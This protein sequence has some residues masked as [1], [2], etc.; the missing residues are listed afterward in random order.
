ML[1]VLF[2]FLLNNYLTVSWQ[3]PGAGPLFGDQPATMQSWLQRGVYIACVAAAA[4]FTI[5]FVQR[6]LRSDAQLITR[7][8]TFLVRGAF[9]AVLFV[10]VADMAISFL[11]VEGLLAS[12]VGASTSGADGSETLWSSEVLHCPGSQCFV[13]VV[14]KRRL[15]LTL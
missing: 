2:A 10:G 13:S 12:G 11:R 4:L 6:T 5:G 15:P 1:A 8:N 9:W 14:L 3:W 7:F